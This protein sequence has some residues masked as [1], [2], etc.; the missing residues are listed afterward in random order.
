MAKGTQT[1]G[2][3]GSMGLLRSV[4]IGELLYSLLRRWGCK[5]SMQHMCQFWW[6]RI[7]CVRDAHRSGRACAAC[8]LHSVEHV[9]LFDDLYEELSLARTEERRIA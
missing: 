3:F 8:D 5:V 6:S 9:Q 7:D 1:R 2:H 4:A